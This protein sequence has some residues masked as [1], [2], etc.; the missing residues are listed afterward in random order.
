MIQPP[1]KPDRI[2]RLDRIRRGEG[3]SA[4]K[5]NRSIETINRLTQ[6]TRPARQVVPPPRPRSRQVTDTV[7]LT[8]A[9]VVTDLSL[10]VRKVK[11]LASPPVVGEPPAL[12]GYAWDGP[13]F[14]AFPDFGAVA[15]DYADSFSVIDT[16]PT[17]GDTFLQVFA[18]QGVSIVELRDVQAL[19]LALQ[20]MG[21]DHL[22]C[23]N[24]AGQTFMVAKPW[25]ARR[26]PFDGEE[27]DGVSYVY[28]ADDRRIGTI[29]EPPD[30]ETETQEVVPRFVVGDEIY[31]DK[32]DSTGVEVEGIPV[33]LVAKEGREF[34]KVAE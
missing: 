11:Y 23:V 33:T 9:P 21:P 25:L 29:G 7:V 22:E 34:A 12:A 3:L 14:T 15:F 28:T 8:V 32:A 5:T 13:P 1:P 17:V 19:R 4:A 24:D 27:R 20:A 18:H 2:P 16:V 10:T 31:A 26:T 30:E 6:G